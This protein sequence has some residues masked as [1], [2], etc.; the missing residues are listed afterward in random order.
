MAANAASPAQCWQVANAS[1][2]V[3]QGLLLLGEMCQVSPGLCDT[4]GFTPDSVASLEA[5][6]QAKLIDAWLT[7]LQYSTCSPCFGPSLALTQ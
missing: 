2:K 3:L 1:A 7:G 5:A 6:L 4:A